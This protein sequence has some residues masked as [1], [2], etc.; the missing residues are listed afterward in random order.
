MRLLRS[1]ALFIGAVGIITSGSCRALSDC[2]EIEWADAEVPRDAFLT[3]FREFTGYGPQQVALDQPKLCDGD[4][5][6]LIRGGGN[7]VPSHLVWLAKV[8]RG[9]SRVNVYPAE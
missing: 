5:F 2:R 8:E 7:Q 6:V 4:M 1:V 9:S 3:A